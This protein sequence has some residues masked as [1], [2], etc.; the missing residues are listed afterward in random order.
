MAVALIDYC[1]SKIRKITRKL[2]I[3]GSWIITEC[4][5]SSVHPEMIMNV[6]YA[7]INMHVFYQYAR[8]KQLINWKSWYLELQEK[9]P[10]NEKIF[11]I[12]VT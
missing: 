3:G 5:I 1:H 9:L 12:L 7:W 2:K 10:G 8:T 6:A 11:F 4:E